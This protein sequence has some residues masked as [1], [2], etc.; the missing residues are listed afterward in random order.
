MNDCLIAT[1]RLD[2]FEKS[3]K[4]INAGIVISYHSFE[5]EENRR[6]HIHNRLHGDAGNLEAQKQNYLL[7]QEFMRFR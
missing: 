4:E 6:D 2:L 5:V 7:C 1:K 3:I